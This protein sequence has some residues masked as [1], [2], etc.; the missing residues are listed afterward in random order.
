[1]GISPIDNE[2]Y[3]S[4]H[5]PKGGDFFGKVTKGINYGWMLVAWGRTDY[6]GSK[7]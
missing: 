5:G 4:N 6:D 7:I 2:L 3:I 1:M